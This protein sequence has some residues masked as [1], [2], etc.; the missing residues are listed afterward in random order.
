MR[1]YPSIL[2]ALSHI[3]HHLLSLQETT[4]YRPGSTLL[5]DFQGRCSHNQIYILVRLPISST[6]L[7][8]NSRLSTACILY[9]HLISGMQLEFPGSRSSDRPHEHEVFYHHYNSPLIILD[10]ILHS[11]LMRSLGKALIDDSIP[12]EIL[13]QF[14]MSR[15]VS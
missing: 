15:C 6:V 1:C 9:F 2:R 4:I 11:R 5:D 3:T 13:R 12:R 10:L 14:P 8:P 7:Y